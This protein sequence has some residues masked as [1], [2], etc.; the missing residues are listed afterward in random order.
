MNR[1]LT[2]TR[3]ARLAVAAVA[4]GTA[5]GITATAID[6]APAQDEEDAATA[7]EYGLIA[8]AVEH[9]GLAVLP[10]D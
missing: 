3:L 8:A 4:A 10:V 7:I 5:Y 9:R 2:T 1:A 6:F